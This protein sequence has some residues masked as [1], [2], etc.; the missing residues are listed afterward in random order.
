MLLEMPHFEAFVAVGNTMG[1]SNAH[2]S[3]L[4]QVSGVGGFEGSERVRAS[5]SS[6]A[7]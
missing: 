3:I 7:V 5:S 6:A 1:F 2:K 4:D